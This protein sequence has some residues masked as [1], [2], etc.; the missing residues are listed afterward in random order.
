MSGSLGDLTIASGT[1]SSGS[2]KCT[3]AKAPELPNTLRGMVVWVFAKVE[4]MPADVSHSEKSN[5]GYFQARFE[6]H[7]KHAPKGESK[8]K[9]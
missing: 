2:P 7:Q 5:Q 4:A 9:Y 8:S 3:L 1:M 6:L